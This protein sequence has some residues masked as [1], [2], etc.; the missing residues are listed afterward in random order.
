MP[1]TVIFITEQFFAV[2]SGSIH[3]IDGSLSSDLVIFKD[4]L[5]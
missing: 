4:Q 5:I 3:L 1:P 2:A